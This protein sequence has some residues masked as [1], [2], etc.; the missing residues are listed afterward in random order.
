MVGSVA[1]VSIDLEAFARRFAD[2]KVGA[3]LGR[4][5]IKRVTTVLAL[6]HVAFE[7]GAFVP[8]PSTRLHSDFHPVLEYAAQRAF[9]ARGD[10][11][12]YRRISEMFSARPRT[13]L[14]DYL[15]VHPLTAEDCK[16]LA[17]F[18]TARRFPGND[19]LRTVLYRWLREQPDATAPLKQLVTLAGEEPALD[20]EMARL[21]K[22][23]EFQS[24]EFLRDIGL[25][26][27]YSGLLLLMHRAQRSEV[28]LPPT[29]DLER[30]L[31]ALIE[32]DQPNQREHRL[33]LAELA[34]DRGDDDAC[35]QLG[36]E[37]LNPSPL[38]GPTSARP[39][40]NAGRAVLERMINAHLSR[41][42]VTNAWQLVFDAQRQGYLDPS[43]ES[44]NMRLEI[45]ARRVTALTLPK[46]PDE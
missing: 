46:N 40:L 10:A 22:R 20:S 41:G 2:P 16:A 34:W 36:S 9:F 28:N 29:A 33:H 39:D 3:D 4:V 24:P 1:P 8:E 38:Y 25:L 19:L 35:L 37:A 27:Q 17:D 5:G 6:Q 32:L 30:I 23:R 26:R 7:D 13:L 12:K 21:A 43:V 44:R 14:S 15:K 31:R 45:L 11:T 18:F 42:D